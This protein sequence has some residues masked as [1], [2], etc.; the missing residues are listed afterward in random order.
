MTAIKSVA[1]SMQML[2]IWINHLKKNMLV[3]SISL[4]CPITV[5]KV[6]LKPSIL[7]VSKI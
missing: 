1:S 6:W 4:C 7:I 2:K 3:S 5:I